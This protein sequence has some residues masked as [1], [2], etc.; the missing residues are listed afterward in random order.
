MKF[1]SG[2]GSTLS[3]ICLILQL[4]RQW[5]RFRDRF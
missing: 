4:T 1:I 5:S 3:W 2:T